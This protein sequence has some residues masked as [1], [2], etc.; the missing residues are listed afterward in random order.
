MNHFKII[1]DYPCLFCLS[2]FKNNQEQLS[3]FK[4]VTTHNNLFEECI[5]CVK[6][7]VNNNLFKSFTRSYCNEV[8]DCKI[9]FSKKF[10]EESKVSITKINLI[11][12]T[13]YNELTNK[14]P[15]I[16]FQ[17]IKK[18]NI[19]NIQKHYKLLI[20]I[21]T[22]LMLCLIISLLIIWC[23]YLLY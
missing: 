14:F 16:S 23:T 2:I 21:Y 10:L 5:L 11:I 15:H 9:T 6:E 3:V 19:Y 22:M 4:E 12:E 20:I 17:I 7:C 18:Q 13:I 8:I 1:I